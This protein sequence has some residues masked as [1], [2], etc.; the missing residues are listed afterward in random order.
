MFKI[1]IALGNCDGWLTV[2]KEVLTAASSPSFQSLSP[3]DS[4][5]LIQ[6]KKEGTYFLIRLI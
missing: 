1:H 3:V 6:Y 4:N 2:D 5:G